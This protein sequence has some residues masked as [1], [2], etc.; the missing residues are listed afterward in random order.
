[1]KR[2]HQIIGLLLLLFVPQFVDAQLYRPPLKWKTF[3]SNHFKVIYATDDDSTAKAA[4]RILEYHYNPIQKL[5]GGELSKLPVVLN[6]YNDLSNGY[7]TPYNFRIEVEIPPIKGKVLNPRVGGWMETVLPHELVHAHHFS[8][9]PFFGIPALIYPLWPDAARSFQFSA[10]TGFHEGLAVEYESEMHSGVGGRGYHPFFTNQTNHIFSSDDRWSLGQMISPVSHNRP[11]N[12]HYLGGYDFVTWMQEIHGEK[13]SR[14]IIDFVGRWPFLGFGGAYWWVTNELPN[15]AYERYVNT[16]KTKESER[17]SKLEVNKLSMGSIIDLKPKGEFNRRPIWLNDDVVLFYGRFYD[18]KSGIFSYNV[19]N[20]RLKR[21]KTTNITEDYKFDILKTGELVYARYDIHPKFDATFE[22]SVVALNPESQKER[23]LSERERN[24]NAVQVRDEIWGLGY[25]NSTNK[26]VDVETGEIILN[27]GVHTIIDFDYSESTDKIAIILN[28]HGS[29]GLWILNPDDISS[30]LTIKPTIL[31][32]GGSIYDP[33]WHP[34]ED[35]LL[36]TA[37]INQVM[38]LFEYSSSEDE[39]IQVTNSLY[40][41]FEGS[42]S[43]DGTNIVAIAQNNEE[44][45]L[46]IIN[47]NEKLTLSVPRNLWSEKTVN[48]SRIWT[49]DYQKL[50]SIQ[51]KSF[52]SGISWLRP[53]A[54]LPSFQSSSIGN[55][56]ALNFRGTDVLQQHTWF[57]QISRQYDANWYDFTYRFT[58]FW[59]G[60][61]ARIAKE[62]I[63]ISFGGGNYAFMFNQK[64]ELSMP[65]KYNIEQNIYSSTFY[66]QPGIE[67]ATNGFETANST[68]GYAGQD[69]VNE[70]FGGETLEFNLFTQL[71]YRLIQRTRDLQPSEGIS[72]FAQLSTDL[73]ENAFVKNNAIQATRNGQHD[74]STDVK[75]YGLILGARIFMPSLFRNH[76]FSIGGRSLYQPFYPRFNTTSLLWETGVEDQFVDKQLIYE[77]S[78]RYT[79]PIFFPENGGVLLPWYLQN[80]HGVLFSRTHWGLNDRLGNENATNTTLGIGLRI[81]AGVGN[82]RFDFGVAYIFDTLTSQHQEWIGDF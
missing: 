62:P 76:T 25:N 45:R 18:K 38:N 75:S 49:N 42:Y 20:D 59:P 5:T 53:R 21:L 1:M 46:T 50:D 79:F 73:M 19:K 64:F 8:V 6:H 29:I 43:P 61:E 16:K 14:D 70:I 7:V 74:D 68:V 24:Y 66:L 15:K 30:I 81:N 28:H 44:Q 56:Y 71:N 22:S 63:P 39:L 10:P 67:F 72:L 40:N 47:P 58:G 27:P 31:F 80:L 57:G 36:F 9:V 23:I 78:T 11:L 35:K 17:L 82:F 77:L 3:S 65:L 34:N 33:Q 32:E 26:L 69:L 13:T 12:R 60:V 51:I 2:Y 41:V 54:V 52:N 55:E 4:L 37:D 48:S